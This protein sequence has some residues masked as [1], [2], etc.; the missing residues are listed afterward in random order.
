MNERLREHVP[1]IVEGSLVKVHLDRMPNSG[2]T[3]EINVQ[4]T[5]KVIRVGKA[6]GGSEMCWICPVD[7]PQSKITNF[8]AM[9]KRR[10]MDPKMMITLLLNK[11]WRLDKKVLEFQ[12]RH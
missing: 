12:Y 7:L 11:I 2:P 3:Y 6:R 5:Y 9:D 1:E 8:L 4:D 10:L